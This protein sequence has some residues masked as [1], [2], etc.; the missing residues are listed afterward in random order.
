MTHYTFYTF[1]LIGNLWG[2]IVDIEPVAEAVEAVWW[3]KVWGTPGAK[4]QAA[5]AEKWPGTWQSVAR[6][7]LL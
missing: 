5:V 4:Q 7:Y 2:V 6:C 3:S 1:S